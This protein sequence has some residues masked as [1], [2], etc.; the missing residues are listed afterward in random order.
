MDVV[1]FGAHTRESF[2]MFDAFDR[3][4]IHGLG[5]AVNGPTCHTH[6]RPGHTNCS[7]DKYTELGIVHY[8]RGFS[9]TVGSLNV[10]T[11]LSGTIFSLPIASS[12]PLALLAKFFISVPST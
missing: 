3:G 4:F 7:R 12:S 2:D 10:S 11:G 9:G 1:Y 8:G 5:Y 6:K